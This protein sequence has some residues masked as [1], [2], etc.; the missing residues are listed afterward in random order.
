MNVITD[1]PMPRISDK[2]LM[3]WYNLTR[4]EVKEFKEN[5]GMGFMRK[6]IKK[7]DAKFDFKELRDYLKL[8][9]IVKR[10]VEILL[11]ETEDVGL[12]FRILIG[13]FIFEARER[14]GKMPSEVHE[15]CSDYTEMQLCVSRW[16]HRQ[17]LDSLVKE[18]GDANG[19]KNYRY[20]S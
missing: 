15:Y 11:S 6:E 14:I 18:Y 12:A 4:S 20:G 13:P 19:K 10:Q 9:F 8:V 1:F 7:L 16:M 3:E 17:T 2:Q 5:S